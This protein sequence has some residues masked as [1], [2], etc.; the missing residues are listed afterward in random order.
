MGVHDKDAIVDVESESISNANS[1]SE[2]ASRYQ[3]TFIQ[4]RRLGALSRSQAMSS[5]LTHNFPASLTLARGL[6]ECGV[7]FDEDRPK[8]AMI[9]MNISSLKYV[10]HLAPT[11]DTVDL[12]QSRTSLVAIP[13]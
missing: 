5:V 13:G 8:L 3:C 2:G 11:T 10:R 9:D 1:P 12:A 6:E 4:F 7:V